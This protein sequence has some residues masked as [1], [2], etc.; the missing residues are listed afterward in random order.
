MTG[1]SAFEIGLISWAGRVSLLWCSGLY[2]KAYAEMVLTGMFDDI[3][4]S[5]T[6]KL[7]QEMNYL[8]LSFEVENTFLDALNDTRNYYSIL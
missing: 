1:S 3:H 5:S 8:T 4:K 2:S 6:L 7:F